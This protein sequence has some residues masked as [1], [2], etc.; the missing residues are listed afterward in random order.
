MWQRRR[1]CI[2]LPIADLER[3]KRH[4]QFTRIG[5]GRT[6]GGAQL[7]GGVGAQGVFDHFGVDV[8]AAAD[9]QVFG[10]ARQVQAAGGGPGPRA[11]QERATPRPK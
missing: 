11:S 4:G 3:G 9:D 5:I 1:A 8:V 2:V 6:H 7:H 10:T